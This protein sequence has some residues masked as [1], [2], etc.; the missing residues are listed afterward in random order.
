MDPGACRT[1]LPARCA[2]AHPPPNVA[3]ALARKEKKMKNR[4]RFVML[5]TLA[6]VVALAATGTAQ[7]TV[8]SGK[9]TLPYEVQWGR[10]VLPAGEYSLAMDTIKGPLSV[11]DASGRTRALVFGSRGFPKAEQPTALLV[12]VSGNSRVVRSLNCP[13]WGANL[14]Y[15]EFTQEE[16]ERLA[17]GVGTETIPVRL[18]RR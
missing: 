10:A 11:R 1:D 16:R 12:T 13:A 8:Y 2:G 17:S 9:F 7:G 15:K 3:G 5:L 6:V 4:V 14:V 18:A